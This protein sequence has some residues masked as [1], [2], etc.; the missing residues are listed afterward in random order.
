MPI[1]VIE[2]QKGHGILNLEN[3]AEKSYCR[4]IKG[5]TYRALKQLFIKLC[6]T[7]GNK[8]F[9]VLCNYKIK[10]FKNLIGGKSISKCVQLFHLK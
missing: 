7:L 4:S 6:S 2:I 10:H 9:N 8:R 5:L 3:A 1:T